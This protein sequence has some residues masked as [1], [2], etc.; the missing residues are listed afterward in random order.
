MT[1]VYY[2]T[3]RFDIMD[4]EKAFKYIDDNPND[5]MKAVIDIGSH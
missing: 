1:E 4:F 5:V 2:V 3:Q